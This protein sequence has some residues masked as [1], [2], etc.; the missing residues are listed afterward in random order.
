M[1][2]HPLEE[3]ENILLLN[4]RHFAVDLGELRLAVGTEVLIAE[5]FSDLEIAV[6]SRHHKQLLVELRRL[7][8]C[9]EL[10]GVHS[11]RHNEVA[12]TFGGGFYE[13]RG[14][15]FEEIVLIEVAAQLEADAV[16]QFEIFSH[17]TASQVEIAVFHA[18]I[19]TT[20]GVVL[21]S[22]RR[23]FGAVE[24]LEIRGDDFDVA[25]VEV[26]VLA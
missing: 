13:N 8:Q 1:F 23:N 7:R 14:F 25:G 10:P 4:K 22:E 2:H 19:V 3:V 20:I 26:S 17:G 6:E 21:D 5:T 15:N 18:Q 24:H 16:A 9:V 11:R 12:R